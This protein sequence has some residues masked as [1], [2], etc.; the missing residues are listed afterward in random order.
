MDLRTYLFKNNIKAQE[1][2]SMIDCNRS[3]FSLV[4]NEKTIPSAKYA[5]KI[6]KATGGQVKAHIYARKRADKMIQTAKAMKN[7]FDQE[8]E[9]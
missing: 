6:E 9:L 8:E 1:F 7:S 2:C 4:K 3:Y 5:D